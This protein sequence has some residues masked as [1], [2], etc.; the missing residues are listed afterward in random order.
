[1]SKPSNPL[2]MAQLSLDD[3]PDEDVF[4]SPESGETTQK[5]TPTS[6]NSSAHKKQQRAHNQCETREAHLRAELERVREVN[7]V[8][9]NVAASLEKA[10]ANMG[11]VQRTVESASTLLGTWTRIL[12]QIE[13]N[14]RLILNPNWQGATQDLEDAENEDARRQQEAERRVVEEQRRRE[15]AQR[16]AEEEERRR[17]VATPTSGR[18]SKTRDWAFKRD[19][20]YQSEWDRERLDEWKGQRAGLRGGFSIVDIH[21]QYQCY[22][23]AVAT[24]CFRLIAK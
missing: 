10:K 16:R 17:A 13:H 4:S 14:Q 15:E 6:T 5:Q 23:V 2:D 24:G 19:G 9:E 12:S 20:G 1:M 21:H 18:G 11:T 7:R 3:A 8:I 22:G